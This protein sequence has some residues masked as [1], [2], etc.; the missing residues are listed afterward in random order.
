MPCRYCALVFAFALTSAVSAVAAHELHEHQHPQAEQPFGEPGVS[1][2]V[3]R[4]IQVDMGDTFRF[5]PEKLQVRKGEAVR[6]LVRNKGKLPHEMV[7]GTHKSLAEHADMMRRMPGMEH[8]D[9]NAVQVAAGGQAELVWRF[10]VTGDFQF[11][12]LV[13]GHFE[14]GMV[15]ALKVTQ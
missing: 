4:T 12:C 9:A 8:H 15:G 11:G 6:F 7:L 3:S 5:S 2:K 1:A 13:P 10:T 14:A